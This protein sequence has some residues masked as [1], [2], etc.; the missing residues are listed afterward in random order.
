MAFAH[1]ENRDGVRQDLVT[2][3]TGVAR[4][5]EALSAKFEAST[6][7]YWTGFWHDVGK[8]HPDFQAYLA[9][10]GA[11]RGPDHKGAGALLARKYLEPLVFLIAGHHGGLADGAELKNWLGEKEEDPRTREALRAAEAQLS[12]LE[13]DLALAL[14]GW[15]RSRGDVEFLLRML[16]SALVDAD[17]LDTERHFSSEV[18]CLRGG[19]PSLAEAWAR[20]EKN[21]AR[22]SGNG[23]QVNQVRSEVY[24]ACVEAAHQAQGFYRLTVPTGGGK[25][26]SS[27]AFAL[28]HAVQHQLDRVVVAIP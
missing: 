11:A 19:G 10:P 22:L 6:L 23:S 13:T 9:N 24:K 28:L 26:R 7:G 18:A 27:M 3:L 20:F 25:T 14:P 16:F 5:A 8:F 21:Q 17:F 4:R 12:G 15:A 2:H 1:S